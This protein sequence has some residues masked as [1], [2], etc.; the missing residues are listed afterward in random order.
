MATYSLTGNDTLT[1]FDR[2]FRDF[3]DG[4]VLT[5]TYPNDLFTKSTGKNGNTLYSQNQQGRNVDVEIRLLR[6]SSDDAFMQEEMN[7][8][9]AN[10]ASQSLIS[11][12]FV[13]LIGDGAGNIQR[14]VMTVSGGLFMRK[15]DS[16]DAQDGS[17]D[18]AIAL[19]RLSFADGARSIQ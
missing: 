15:V 2:V 8:R 1:L 13:K 14:D 17:T 10:F 18:A 4:V 16:Q 5:A 12:E 9:I 6:G 7:S 11:G 3:G 19:Y